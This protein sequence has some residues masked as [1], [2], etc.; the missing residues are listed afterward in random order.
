MV[1]PEV[2]DKILFAEPDKSAVGDGPVTLNLIVSVAVAPPLS[3]GQVT[4]KLYGP[5]VEKGVVASGEVTS[6]L[7][8]VLCI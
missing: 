5:E 2:T 7:V 1:P 4:V 6:V 8:E 3:E